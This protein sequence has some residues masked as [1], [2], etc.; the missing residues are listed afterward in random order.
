MLK[1]LGQ[2][3]RP[4]WLRLYEAVYHI[5]QDIGRV[6]HH[7]LF[8]EDRSTTVFQRGR[9]NCQDTEEIICYLPHS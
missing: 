3:K 1:K 4:V 7:N 2:L 8:H 6:F 5:G 9:E